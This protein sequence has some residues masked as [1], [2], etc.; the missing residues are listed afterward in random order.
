MKDFDINI[1]HCTEEEAALQSVCI[2]EADFQTSCFK[3]WLF[4]SP[5]K[6]Q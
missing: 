6:R 2:I 5:K 1:N 4:F 3:L